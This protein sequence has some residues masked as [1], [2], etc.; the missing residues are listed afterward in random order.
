M[1]RSWNVTLTTLL[2][3]YG[4]ASAQATAPVPADSLTLWGGLA[5]EFYVLPGVRV[6]ASVPVGPVGG[7][8]LAV[9]AGAAA[10]ILPVADVT[11][12]LPYA[13]LDALLSKETRGLRVYG[14]PSVG[15]LGG[16]YWLAGGVVGIRNEFQSSAWGWYAEAQPRF[17]F[18]LTDVPVWFAPGTSVGVTYRF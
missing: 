9:R 14:G 5:S 3:A 17:I 2:A 18:G 4:V 7:L 15:T 16:M 12:P 1:T 6:A 11:G 8:N 10:I 13:N